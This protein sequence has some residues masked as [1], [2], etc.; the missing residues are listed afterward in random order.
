MKFKIGDL[1]R[2]KWVVVPFLGVIVLV[3]EQWEELFH[4]FWQD[5]SR[6][7]ADCGDLEVYDEDWRFG[8]D[9]TSF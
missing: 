4:I 7:W 3:H 1:V 5:G 8:M 2:S 6:S 9:S